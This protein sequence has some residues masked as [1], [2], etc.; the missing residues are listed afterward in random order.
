MALWVAIVVGKRA[1]DDSKVKAVTRVAIFTFLLSLFF[2]DDIAGRLYFAYLC[3]N[4]TSVK[5]YDSVDLPTEYWDEN[6][7]AKF[8]NER[9]G[10]FTLQRYEV[11]YNVGTYSPLFHIDHAGY[12]WVDSNTGKVL[13]EVI[14]FRHWGGFVRR[15]FTPHNTANSCDGRKERSNSIIK[16]IFLRSKR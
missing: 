15:E 13:G 5:V 3:D 1:S 14:E 6:G 2:A 10:N 9:N 8:Y 4:K 7:N 16:Q 11:D 12:L